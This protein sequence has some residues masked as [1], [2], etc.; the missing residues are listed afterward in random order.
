MV[1]S[2]CGE[3]LSP[4]G[5]CV[6][7]LLRAGL[8]EGAQDDAAAT[9]RPSE[10]ATDCVFGDFEIARRAD[11]S[12]WELGRGAMGVT[13]RAVDKVL[14]RN[15][16]LKVIETP[17]AKD[18]S[19]AVRERFLREARAAAALRHPNVAGVFHLSASPDVERCYFAMELVE[20]ETL[21]AR[22][23]RDGPLMTD[24]ALEI[25]TQ[26]TRALVA[27]AARGLIHRDL[28][29][30][31]IML[32]RGDSGELE[33]KVIDF[34]LAKAAAEA[35]G[36]M[37]L[38]HGGFVGTPAFAS[39]EQFESGV[40]DVRSDIY[41][42]G[43]TL[44]FAL[45]G[46]VPFSA[47]TIEEMRVCRTHSPLPVEQLVAKKVPAAVISLLRSCLAINPADRPATARELMDALESCRRGLTERDDRG[48][49]GFFHQLRQRKVVKVAIAYGVTAWLLAQ[50][51]TQIFPFFEIPNWG[52]RL[53]ILVL[54]LGFPVALV[55]AW[56]LQIT[57]EGVRLEGG[58]PTE[59]TARH[60]GHK[61]TALIV[62]VALGAVA[63]FAFRFFR[64]S[65]IPAAPN[66]NAPAASMPA[67]PVEKS[68]AVLPLENLSD[69]K[70]NG[71]FADGLQ[72][73]ILT[74]LAKI[75]ELKVISRTSVAQ[76]RGRGPALNLREIAR[77]LGVEH[78][79]EG[80][81][82]R[83]GNRVLVSVQLIDA[84]NDHHIWAE[85]YDRTLADS[86]GLQGELATQIAAA[87]KARLAPEE[88]ARLETRPTG[89]AGAY[90]LY[91]RA[92]GRERAANRST[93]DTVAAGQLY[94]EAIAL[95]PKFAL[96]HARL[97][98]VNSYLAL[99]PSDNQAP[100][101]K[102][103]AEAE[104]AL[105]LSPSL[106]EAHMALGLFLYWA[107]KDYAAALKEFSIAAAT[108]PNE[109][110][111]LQY[112]GGIYRRQGRWRESIAS[113]QRAQDLDPRNRRIVSLAAANYLLVRDW[114]AATACYN[115]AL[116]IAPD[117]VLPR[118]GLAY[119][120]V[121]RN[122][123]P[124][125]GKAILEKIPAGVDPD[126]RVIAARW[127]LAMM[128]RDYATA[129]KILTDFPLEDFPKAGDAPKTFSLGRVALARGDTES[130]QRYFAATAPA[131]EGW[132]RADPD[133]PNRH[134]QLGL[135]Y[136]YMHRKEDAIRESRRAVELEPESQN[137]FHGAN[138]AAK[139]ALVYALVGESDQAITLI[140]RL[141][142]T[143]GPVEWPDFPQ[144][145]TLADLRLRWEWDPLRSNPRFQK[146]L[147]GPEPKTVY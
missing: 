96:A 118:I 88:K 146:I 106:G 10:A 7:C 29:P 77:S 64:Q 127:D 80:S 23:R 78:V 4:K 1:C 2:V 14:H 63:L 20:G 111:I 125:A 141:L 119:L 57:P 28:K 108:S 49:G 47:T 39:P 138:T 54:S 116:E 144:N 48:R 55:L 89:D 69:D 115:R 44:W 103:R 90:A 123:N 98:I 91:L 18:G 147:A 42:L 76:Y 16:A 8:E 92:L 99:G 145:I 6:A 66:N 113:Y 72:D 74:S 31:N 121:F 100:R 27:A 128:E 101:A 93:E 136:A 131:V 102:A 126:G 33:V 68:I 62:V 137:A 110:D 112:I 43:A 9:P 45:T 70:E 124:T 58:I 53:V 24:V 3:P 140:E 71:F 129:E 15:V 46:R 22:V 12:L 56:A 51:A 50:I 37:D 130:A 95:D 134:A 81:V 139:L 41:A 143:P 79:L 104:E 114:P 117:S 67:M 75:S 52:V 120:E 11:G 19:Q 21:E 97:S 73:D 132:V 135:L 34:G 61:L 36:E 17:T 83:M 94:A 109:P 133:D 25:A 32:A 105:R 86:L 107:E 13:Y 82:R 38:T 5:G 122:G 87:L 35:A 60:T 65:A 40:V 84:R 30:G 26:V 85:R 59:S 142:S